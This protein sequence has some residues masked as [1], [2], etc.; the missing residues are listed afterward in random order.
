VSVAEDYSLP[1]AS[2]DEWWGWEWEKKLDIHIDTLLRCHNH[3]GYMF[4]YISGNQSSTD[5]H[6]SCPSPNSRRNK[7]A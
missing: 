5:R 3:P 4:S 7:W 1:S 6:Y 2:A